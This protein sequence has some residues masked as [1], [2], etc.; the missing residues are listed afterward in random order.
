ML[1]S[2]SL[3]FI[4]FVY[5]NCCCSVMSDPLQPHGLQHTRLLCSSLSPRLCS[6]SCPLSWWCDPTISFSV[7]PFSS[8][9]QSFLASGSFPMNQLFTSGG[10]GIGASSSASVLTMNVQVWFPLRWTDLI[11]LLSKGLSRVFSI[12]TVWKHWFFGASFLFCPNLTSI[13]DYW[14]IHSFDYTDLCRQ[15]DVSAF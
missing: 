10:Q 11:S 7:T 9:P 8:C 6:N 5:S 3:L 4:C 13:H 2:S 15:S 12:I 1:Y 14:K